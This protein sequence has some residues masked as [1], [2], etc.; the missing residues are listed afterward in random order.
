MPVGAQGFRLALQAGLTPGGAWD[1]IGGA[2]KASSRPFVL[3]LNVISWRKDRKGQKEQ[4]IK[5]QLSLNLQRSEN[6]GYT[7]FAHLFITN[8][9]PLLIII[10]KQTHRF[11]I[12]V[13]KL[14][15]ISNYLISILKELF[16]KVKKMKTLCYDL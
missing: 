11:L 5:W 9:L 3:P 2:C 7:N 4:I 6:S 8:M 10:Q 1:T 16:I 15:S 13:S 12:G 14:F